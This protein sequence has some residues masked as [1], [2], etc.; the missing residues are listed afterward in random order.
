M[1]SLSADT[2]SM[3]EDAIA[4]I[5]VPGGFDLLLRGT[6]V[7]HHRQAAPCLFV[8]AGNGQVI[9][10]RGMFT[11]ED[12]LHSRL[13]LAH[14]RIGRVGSAWHV[15]F[16]AV[17]HGPCLLLAVID[18]TGNDAVI[19]L[20]TPDP[21]VNRL[22]IRLDAEPGEHVW[23]GG[24]QFS[25]FDLRGRRFP[26]WTS[27]PGV[28]R[29]K[30][31]LV[32]FEAD[33]GDASGGGDYYHTYFPQPTLLS[34]RRYALHAETTA[35]A[36]FDFRAAAFHE[37][38]FWEV[39]A[40]IELWARPNFTD[41]V[42]CL[43]ARFGRQ[44]VLPDW[45][46]QGAI[47]GLKAGDASFD[48]LAKI[49]AA[50]AAVSGLWC[51]DWVGIR[52]TNFGKRLFWDW[53]WNNQRYP[54]HA[55][56][57]A[58]LQAAGIRFL[59]YVNPY[60]ATDGKLYVEAMEAGY[61]VG[62]PQGGP[63]LLDFGQF[64]AAM[65]D[66][67]NADAADWFAERIIGR[68]MIDTGLAGWMADFGEYLPVEG[69]LAHGDGMTAHNAWPV[70]WAEVSAR[71]VASR[72]RTGDIVFFMRAGYTGVQRHCP[73]LWGGDQLVDFSRHDGIGTAIVAA[74]SS[75]LLGNA[76]H[77]SDIGGYTSLFGVVRT[78]DLLMRWSEM[79]AFT[80]V[81]RS[82]E[83][84][85]PDDNLQLDEDPQVL[86]HFAR[87]TRIYRHLAPYLRALSEQAAAHGLP[88]QRPL[89][90]HF[91]HDPRAYA[92]QS[93]YL[94][95]PDLLVAPVIEPDRTSWRAYLPQGATWRHLWTGASMPGGQEVE[96][97]AP[98]GQPPVWMRDGS[99][100]TELFDGLRAL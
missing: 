34:S 57:L 11:L 97:A 49:R 84:N 6:V 20:T 76:Y 45:L 85:R 24:E 13:P 41:L 25:Y 67:T 92:E 64:Q 75:G 82:H 54:N 86:A 37:L 68:E 81:M 74:L 22:W 51:E 28:G 30:S 8:G 58:E 33:R 56:R 39:P 71:A 87:M 63:F 26:L 88:M 93:S 46:L 91:E 53:R 14:A 55:A 66:F 83:G 95:G 50:G 38:E 62:S 65:V 40:R 21:A 16:A 5:V 94:F 80:S 9:Q 29:D 23:G 48:R 2:A 73:L 42:G 27:E 96:V 99:A 69:V 15:E 100:W 17:E 77:H 36:V 19:A 79:A 52:L 72:G 7:L 31:T 70:L 32:T 47:I 1:Q 60:L 98:Y 3:P 4:L 43:S 90:L 35:Y 59:G 89:F 44:P 18:A 12:R 78:A 10:Q 61:L